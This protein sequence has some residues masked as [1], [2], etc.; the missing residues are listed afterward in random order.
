MSTRRPAPTQPPPQARPRH[1]GTTI[2]GAPV[3]SLIL[4]VLRAHARLGTE[5]LSRVGVTPPHEIVLLYL[6]DHGPLPQA[7]LVHYMARDR[8]TVT[9]TLQAME[10]NGLVERTVSAD[11][12]RAMV[13]ALTADGRRAVPGARDAWRELEQV[14]VGGLDRIQRHDLI[15]ALTTVRDRLNQAIDAG[16]T[17]D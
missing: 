9:A 12:R 17:G 13:V 16:V 5:L 1:Q 7:E 8:S 15:T 3:G 4:Q 11:D 10:R 2:D 14:T 6:D